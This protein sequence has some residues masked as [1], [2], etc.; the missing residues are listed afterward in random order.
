[1]GNLRTF[2]DTLPRY[3]VIIPVRHF[4]SEEPVLASLRAT[5]PL[6]GTAQILVAEGG[7]PAR[8]RNAAL[9]KARGEI[10]VFLDN[11]C[12][13]SADFWQELDTAFAQPGVEVVGGPALLRPRATPLEE[14]FHALLTHPLLVGTMSARYAPRGTFRESTKTDLILCNLA[15]K[16]TV[17]DKISALSTDLYPNEENEWLDRAHGAH[18]GIYYCPSLQVFRPQRATWRDMG[19]MLFRY[20][21][22]RT[23]QFWV[24]GWHLTFHQWLPV[25]LIATFIALFR[26]HLEV[27]FVTL[28]LVAS[29]I[30]ALSCKAKLCLWQRIVA[31][32]VAPLLPLTYT[33]GQALGWIALLIPMPASTSPIVL[34][35]ER[36]E[37]VEG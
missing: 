12:S 16:R 7:H 20:G 24:S 25:I 35:N 31:G 32:L 30:I 15:V 29:V 17:F 36:G 34:R 1:M 37:R 5:V 28:W 33:L 8:Q 3:T 27:E 23:R 14:I 21:M 11:D 13:L 19:E 10:I 9:A 6:S 18:V 4:R 22:G 2:M 26:W